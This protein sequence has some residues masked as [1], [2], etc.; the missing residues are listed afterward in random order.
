MANSISKQEMLCYTSIRGDGFLQRVHLFSLPL[1]R[2]WHR[3]LNTGN[4]W[5]S[6]SDWA[7]KYGRQSF[8]DWLWSAIDICTADIDINGCKQLCG[9][10]Y[11]APTKSIHIQML[12]DRLTNWNRIGIGCNVEFTYLTKMYY[13][14]KRMS[15]RNCIVIGTAMSSYELRKLIGRLRLSMADISFTRWRH[16]YERGVWLMDT[17]DIELVTRRSWLLHVL[18]SAGYDW[19]SEWLL[20]DTSV[21]V[22]I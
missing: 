1:S 17:K 21:Q 2:E 6:T 3:Q 19:L 7:L 4:C 12:L 15:T 18:S 10:E 9:V 20:C 14:A 8:A 5:S 16:S 11:F 22:A 13:I